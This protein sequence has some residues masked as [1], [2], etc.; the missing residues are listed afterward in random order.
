M[1]WYVAEYAELDGWEPVFALVPHFCE[2]TREYVWLER[3]WRRALPD[4][5]SAYY[6]YRSGHPFGSDH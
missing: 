4:R 2:D 5:M 3:I 6:E 1:R